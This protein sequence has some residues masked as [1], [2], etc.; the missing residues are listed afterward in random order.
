MDIATILDGVR[1]L[2]PALAAIGGVAAG[3]GPLVFLVLAGATLAA[4]AIGARRP[5]ACPRTC[6]RA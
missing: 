6:P 5:R 1:T 2:A 3:T 4:A